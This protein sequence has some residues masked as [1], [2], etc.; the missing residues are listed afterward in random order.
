MATATA[1]RAAHGPGGSTV[2][3]HQ[4]KGAASKSY[5]VVRYSGW[6]HP[7]AF[8]AG[9]LN[10]P[11]DVC[12]SEKKHSLHINGGFVFLMNAGQCVGAYCTAG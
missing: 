12:L 5:S 10:E 8:L 7:P 2:K 11:P 3:G 9:H 6:A 4:L 1:P